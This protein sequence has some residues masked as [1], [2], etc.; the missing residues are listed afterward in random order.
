M[1]KIEKILFKKIHL[2]FLFLLLLLFLIFSILFASILR[3]HYKNGTNF[4]TLQKIA[5][6]IAEIPSNLKDA[7]DNKLRSIEI[8]NIDI[9]AARENRFENKSGF[10]ITRNKDID[11][12]LVL[13]RS[14]YE[15]R[16][17]IVEIIDLKNYKIL[18]TYDPYSVIKNLTNKNKPGKN[19]YVMRGN[20]IVRSPFLDKDLNLTFLTNSD[21]LVQINKDGK[22]NW[23]RDDFRYHHTFEYLSS[24]NNYGKEVLWAIGYDMKNRSKIDDV[25]YRKEYQDDNLIKVDYKTGEVLEYISMTQVFIKH[26]LHNELFTGRMDRFAADPLHINDV[27]PVIKSS[28]YFKK[29][30]LFVS[31]AHTNMIFLF[32]PITKKILWRT[33]EG[34]F[35]QHDIDIISQSKISV[36]NNNRIT[37]NNDIVFKPNEINVFDFETNKMTS[38]YNK[39]LKEIDVRTVNQGIHEK[40]KFGTLVEEQNFGRLV[41]FDKDGTIFEYINRGSNGKLYQLHW[42]RLIKD[43][44]IIERIREQL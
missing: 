20:S 36:F 33:K 42:S 22:L 4:K 2:Y 32:D 16:R 27:Q 24:Q 43:K 44:S 9:T 31:S 15:K 17:Q 30:Q 3:H 12:I 6:F 37:I 28:R 39:F 35:H 5:V 21:L 23:Y 14:D 25:F 40:T 10:H 41:F 19:E 1:N 8:Q 26:N 38:P 34:L 29:G 7:F 11:M 13:S 18:K